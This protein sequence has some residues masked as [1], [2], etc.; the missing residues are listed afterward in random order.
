[1]SASLWS[2][3]G[4][5]SV[6]ITELLLMDVQLRPNG[7]VLQVLLIFE[8]MFSDVLM[9]EVLVCDSL[10][11]EVMFWDLLLIKFVPSVLFVYDCEP[12]ITA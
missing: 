3:V 4:I 11:F 9:S 1:M 2:D 7:K 10:L 8:V 12:G 5:F 6:F